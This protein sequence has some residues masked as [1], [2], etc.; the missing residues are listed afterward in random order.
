M[1]KNIPRQSSPLLVSY[2][3]GTRL[4]WLLK[5]LIIKVRSKGRTLGLR[6]LHDA[7]TSKP[8]LVLFF[9]YMKIIKVE[10]NVVLVLFIKEATVKACLCTVPWTQYT[11]LKLPH[12]N[13][14]FSRISQQDV[15]ILVITFSY[16]KNYMKFTIYYSIP[17]LLTVMTFC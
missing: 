14:K 3:F 8:P 6:N 10:F 13:F 2:A 7:W 12:S 9:S 15:Q 17:E 1:V 4:S 16:V 5:V 11:N